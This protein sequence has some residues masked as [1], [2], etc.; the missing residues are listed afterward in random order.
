MLELTFENEFTKVFVDT[1]NA[2]YRYDWKGNN[3]YLTP[4]Q[5]QEEINHHK[6]RI[7]EYKPTSVLINCT[8]SEFIIPPD[9]QQF[10]QATLLDY[11]SEVGTKKLAIVQGRDFVSALSAKQ[12][13]EARADDAYTMQFFSTE[14]DASDWLLEKTPVI[15]S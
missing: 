4:E 6:K 13:F 12:T 15:S 14:S 9:L 11:L 1:E 8:E 2:I 7:A 10:V 3:R 5:Y